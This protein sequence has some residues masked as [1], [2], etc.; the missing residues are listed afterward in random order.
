MGRDICDKA[1]KKTRGM[2]KGVR[3]VSAIIDSV[4]VSRSQSIMNSPLE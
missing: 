2:R 1:A 3:V 4:Y